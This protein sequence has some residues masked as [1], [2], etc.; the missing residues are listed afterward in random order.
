[1]SRETL[2]DFL[3][4][5]GSTSTMLTYTMKES[6]DG[7]GVDPGT[8]EELLDLA[9][10]VNGLLGDY[11]KFIVDNSSNEYKFNSGNS[12]HTDSNKGTDL[13]IADTY[14]TDKIH[15]EQGSILKAK[16][17]EYSNSGYFNNSGT[18]LDTLVDKVGASFSNNDTLKN[19]QGRDL[20]ENGLTRINP[21][22]ENNDVVKATQKLFLKNNRF[23]NVS[24]GETFTDNTNSIQNIQNFETNSSVQGSIKPQNKFGKYEKDGEVVSL[25]DLKSI[26]ASILLKSSGFAD[27]D[28]PKSSGLPNDII[29]QLKDINSNVI[30]ENGFNKIDNELIRAKNAKG[31]PEREDGNSFREGRGDIIGNDPNA[32]N[33]KSFGATY[34]PD[35]SFTNKNFLRHKIEA[36]IS[37]L[38]LKAIGKSFFGKFIDALREKDREDLAT[39]GEKFYSENPKSD[40]IVYM[41]GKSRNMPSLLIDDAI[42]SNI[43]TNTTYPYGNCIDRGF[44]IILGTDS[45]AINEKSIKDARSNKLIS[46]SPGFWLAVARSVIKNFNDISDKYEDVSKGMDT[47]DLYRF[48]KDIVRENSIIKFFNTM[49]VIGEISLKSTGGISTKEKVSHPRDVDSIPDNRAIPGKSRKSFGLNKNELSWNQ[50]AS[51]SMYLLPANII[52]AASKLNNTIYGESPVRGMFGSKLVRNTYTGLDV[53]GSY[54]RI[55]N[56]VV[57]IL[58]DKLEAEYVPF[59]IQDLRTNEIISFNAFLSQLT[60]SIN[61]S[62]NAVS[63]YGRLDPVQIYKGTTRNLQVGFTLYA[64][65]REDFDSMWYKIN[66]FVT[67]LYPQWTPGDMVSNSKD[68][69]SKFIQP[70][71]QVMGGSPIVRLRIGDVIKSNYSRFGLA[72]MFGIGDHGVSPNVNDSLESDNVLASIK[73]IE[74]TKV[75][76]KNTVTTTHDVEKIY[77]Q[78]TESALKVWLAAFGSAHSTLNV[79]ARDINQTN[80]TTMQ[81]VAFNAGKGT[82]FQ[83]LSNMMVNGFANPLAVGGIIRQ[84]R[85]PNVEKGENFNRGTNTV[86]SRLRNNID[87]SSG[88]NPKTGDGISG[89]YQT[90]ATFLRKMILKPNVVNGYYC[91]DD[92]KK[93]LISRGISVRIIKKFVDTDDIIRYQAKVID[94]SGAPSELIRKTLIVNHSDIYPDP[95]ELFTNSI[96]GALL[97]ATDPISSVVDTAVSLADDLLLNAGIGND[98]TDF[99]RTLYSSNESFFMKKELNPFVRAFETNKGRGL[100]GVL[101]GVT[102]TWL[103]DKTP[104]EL[105]YNA[106]A[107]IGVNISF[108]FDVIHDLPPGLDHSGYNRAP[109]YN[110][111]NIMR[112]ISGDVYSDD[113]RQGEFYYK[114]EGS[115]TYR[116]FGSDNNATVKK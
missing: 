101:G 30:G 32:R 79:F 102:F 64:T 56:E 92:G 73:T 37:L 29:N 80:W 100:A 27:G 71:S 3:N 39:T 45:D 41:L 76:G 85:D 61:P 106:R 36:A 70:F 2:K 9:N 116:V 93:Y 86:M 26:A 109:L 77:N 114:E 53:D 91:E 95:K 82:A 110:V 38:T 13:P 25:E 83:L 66:K 48:Y 98:V 115:K 90:A 94:Y 62:F 4:S 103:D 97:F 58:E 57:K 42:F 44:E 51:P 88:F 111:G 34:N 17:N 18:N 6:P 84:L 72:R 107:P 21:V 1:M 43:L 23:S 40:P 16:L 89:G 50:D 8:N 33:S 55:P 11:L 104:W 60:D 68:G 12:K 112:N 46:E 75:E 31:F 7:L 113:G 10:T 19:I 24:G 49:A 96:V 99:I 22:G 78:F 105:D 67:L 35:F 63:G 5:K 108:K 28:S 47:E 54:N 74:T 59:Y 52:R 87:N 81:K 69:S 14:G 20:D 65:N 15:V